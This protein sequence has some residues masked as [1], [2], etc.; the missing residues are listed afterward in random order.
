M[1]QISPQ[2]QLFATVDNLFNSRYS[3]Y[4]ILSDPTGIGAPGIPPGSTTNEPGV[5]N[6]FESPAAPFAIFGGI[7]IHLN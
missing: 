3:T 1:Y 2:V 5:N 7:R 4:G 6:R